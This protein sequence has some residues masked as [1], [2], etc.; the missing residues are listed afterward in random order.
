V[1]SV[2]G[3]SSLPGGLGEFAEAFGLTGAAGDDDGVALLHHGVG[4]GVGEA[5]A[6]AFDRDDGD[7]V[8]GAHPAVAQ[9]QADDVL[10]R[11]GL[12]HGEVVLELDVVQHPAA[13]RVGDA[14]AHVVLGTADVVDAEPTQDLLLGGV[15]A[16]HVGEGAGQGLDAVWLHGIGAWA[17]IT[18]G[19]LEVIY[20]P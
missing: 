4:G 17:L 15:G 9:R 7:A 8:A 19:L 11:A 6:G 13:H 2:S 1:P 12:D 18:A 14:L 5:L 10:R 3:R 16:H 20:R